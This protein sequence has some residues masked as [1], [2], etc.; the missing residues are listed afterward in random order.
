MDPNGASDSSVDVAK[1][2]RALAKQVLRRGGTF[3]EKEG[4]LIDVPDSSS[5]ADDDDLQRPLIAPASMPILADENAWQECPEMIANDDW[6]QEDPEMIADGDYRGAM[7]AME[8][9][10][11]KEPQH[12]EARA[13]YAQARDAL[14][15]SIEDYI[16]LGSVLFN[17]SR[18]DEASDYFDSVLMVEPENHIA[19]TYLKRIILRKQTLQMFNTETM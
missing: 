3:D 7:E 8:D 9:I 4:S 13:L 17:Q 18:Y 5:R 2:R 16:E 15:A 1:R 14:K 11:H 19:Q 6:K 10:L 12:K